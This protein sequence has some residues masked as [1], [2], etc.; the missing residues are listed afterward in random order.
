MFRVLHDLKMSKSL[1]IFFP[2]YLVF[3]TNSVDLN[4]L[5]KVL[6]DLCSHT[7]SLV[8]YMLMLDVLCET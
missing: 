1:D 7:F 2:F 5:E 6:F 8:W 4:T 3:L